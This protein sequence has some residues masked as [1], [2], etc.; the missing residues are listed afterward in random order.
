M[1]FNIKLLNGETRTVKMDYNKIYKITTFVKGDHEERRRFYTGVYIESIHP[2]FMVVDY[3]LGYGYEIP[4]H[5]N[6]TNNISFNELED[7]EEL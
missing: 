4:K 3:K 5:R 2:T 6:E 1:E 7:I